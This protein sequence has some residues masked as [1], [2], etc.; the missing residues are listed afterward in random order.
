M[1]LHIHGVFWLDATL[2]ANT[3]GLDYLRPS[4]EQFRI[5]VFEMALSQDGYD[6]AVA[7]LVKLA[8]PY[9]ITIGKVKR[10]ATGI[11][12]PDQVI[13]NVLRTGFIP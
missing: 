2:L 9:Q 10:I 12:V 6:R 11:L 13:Q 4:L 7:K 3:S 8:L 1:S 5:L